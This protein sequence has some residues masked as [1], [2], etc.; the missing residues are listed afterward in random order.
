MKYVTDKVD[1]VKFYPFD[2]K[3]NNSSKNKGMVIRI[4]N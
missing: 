2:T 1:N 4:R 3:V